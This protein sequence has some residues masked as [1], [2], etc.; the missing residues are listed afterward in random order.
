[1]PGGLVGVVQRREWSS[2]KSFC[3]D[4]N[5]LSPSLGLF[6]LDLISI[7]GYVLKSLCIS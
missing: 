6:S 4:A 5:Y 1:M 3:A 7:I 2:F